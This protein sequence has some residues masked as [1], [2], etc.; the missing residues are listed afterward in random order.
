MYTNFMYFCFLKQKM[1][2]ILFSISLLFLNLKIH[3]QDNPAIT[4]WVQ[5][6]NS[7]KSRLIIVT[8]LTELLLNS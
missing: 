4:P 3:S 7:M 5:N 2:K 6:T 8:I 1:Y